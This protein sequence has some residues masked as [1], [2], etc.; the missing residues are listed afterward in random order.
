MGDKVYV[1]YENARNTNITGIY[2]NEKL[3]KKEANERE[4][5]S[6]IESFEIQGH[7]QDR[8]DYQINEDCKYYSPMITAIRT[9]ISALYDLEGCCCGG[10]A[11]VVTDDNNFD[12]D[13]LDWV[14]DYCNEEENKDRVE[15]EWVIAIMKEL[16][17]LTMPQRALI[18][19]S[20]YGLALCTSPDCSTC[21]I[22]KGK[23]DEKE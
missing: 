21:L 12:D 2:A 13:D 5:L 8:F 7:K 1:T 4:D 3:A 17:K 19:S 18:F 15:K 11:H 22:P 20:Y 14:I 16:K 9:M 10:L 6:L 23:I